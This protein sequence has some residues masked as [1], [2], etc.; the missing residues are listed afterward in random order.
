MKI[1]DR[2]KTAFRF[3]ENKN[4]QVKQ[5]SLH[6]IESGSSGIENYSGYISEEYLQKLRGE[7]A[8][9]VYDQMRRSDSN[10][11]M[12]LNAVSNPIKGASWTVVSKDNSE[13]GE[14]IKNFIEYIVFN[15]L[16]KSWT[17]KL[18][19]I[20]TCIPFGFSVFEKTHKVV[21]GH[22]RFGNYNGLKKLAWRSPKTITRWNLDKES[23]DLE[24][25]TQQ[26]F[27]DIGKLVDIY[28]NDLVI[29]SVNRE[30][31]NFEGISALRPCYGPFLRKN[32]YL[33]LLAIGIEKYAVP[34]PTLNVPEGKENTDQYENA[35]EVLKRYV[36]HQQQFITKPE[37]W[38][39]TFTTNNF[40]ADKIKQ[41]IEMENAEMTKAFL[42][43]FML[44]G[45]S[46]S[47]SYALSTDLSDFFLGGIEYIAQSICDTF[48][49]VIIPELVRLNFGQQEYYP[50]L[51]A[52]GIRD[53]AGKELA[54]ILSMLTEKGL[55]TKDEQLEKDIRN[56]YNLPEK[57]EI[58]PQE[59]VYQ[60]TNK[61][62]QPPSST[63]N[64]Q[65]DLSKQGSSDSSK[66]L[67]EKILK[68]EE[69]K[70]QIKNESEIILEIMQR[71]L[72]KIG[73]NAVEQLVK[74]WRNATDSQKLTLANAIDF[75]G[76]NDYK[77]ELL[78]AMVDASDRAIS[79]ARKEIPSKKNIRLAEFERLPTEVKKRLKMLSDL[80][81]DSQI[82]EMNKALAFG[83]MAS[84]MSTDSGDLLLED[85]AE[86]MTKMVFGPSVTT[87]AA[88]LSSDVI[89]E[90]RQAF[91]YN[92]EVF[93]EIESFTF[94]NGDPVSP[95]CQALAGVTFD[96][97]D[98]D[99]DR[100]RPPLHHNCKSTLMA[101]LKGRKG[102]DEITPKSEWKKDAVKADKYIT[103]SEGNLS[104]LQI[105]SV[106]VSKKLAKSLEDA[107][108]YA[109]Q[110]VT[111][112]DLVEE[113]ENEYCFRQ[114]DL[115][116]IS[117]G[118]LKSYEPMDGINLVMGN[119]KDLQPVKLAEKKKLQCVQVSKSIA[120]T[121]A[122]AKRFCVEVDGLPV[123]VDEVDGF[124]RFTQLDA[125][126]FE[127]GS[128]ESKEP[129][130]G[131][132]CFYG[133]LIAKLSEKFAEE[134]WQLQSLVVKKTSAK[135]LAK[136]KK[137]AKE[138]GANTIENLDENEDS[139]RFRQ[140]EPSI[141]S[142][143]RS[144]ELANGVTLIYGLTK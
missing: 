61:D 50:E 48:N 85:L 54:E 31:D 120:A 47:G 134:S 78:Q 127:Q 49:R 86:K 103:F 30:G 81:L 115:G 44:L 124:Y 57:Q 9:D 102:N 138:S 144:K 7:A 38:D 62:I 46:G 140:L 22:S 4:S 15:D 66:E 36:S 51:K 79:Q 14:K 133:K 27:G 11:A 74:D 106:R 118:T 6:V 2:I 63:A 41:V 96:K 69:P 142:Q 16:D 99:L 110:Y 139:F 76:L 119:M 112:L 123:N 105:Q 75:K 95:I 29:F 104:G 67:S 83:Y 52:A 136:A 32:I 111:R 97:N 126:L 8:A 10:I 89:N 132:L 93:D 53:R 117:E 35:I 55:L 33:K 20:L 128:I 143:F 90:S 125:G 25:I 18:G 1:I 84:A 80:V 5:V 130:E 101:N 34:T 24:S 88:N 100:Y 37:G 109:R 107:R 131:V 135:T 12:L 72:E 26:A 40:D 92:D 39:I 65:G 70:K 45:Q 28:A 141:F 129:I 116:L 122:D 42:A 21:V 60:V 19:E 108:A 87:G 137:L 77:A 17:E 114:I 59:Q 91:F 64:E 58:K 13:Q 23:G 94:V 113:N 43:N 121:L 3:Q 98:P 82:S 73:T 71:N 56:R 68:L